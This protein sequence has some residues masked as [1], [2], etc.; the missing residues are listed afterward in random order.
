MSPTYG[1]GVPGDKQPGLPPRSLQDLMN[2][3][4]DDPA[5]VGKHVGRITQASNEIGKGAEASGAARQQG[6]DRIRTILDELNGP[7]A[8]PKRTEASEDPLSRALADTSLGTELDSALSPPTQREVIAVQRGYLSM[9]VTSATQGGSMDQETRTMLIKAQKGFQDALKSMRIELKRKHPED[10]ERLLKEYEERVDSTLE[11]IL[12]TFVEAS[13][14]EETLSTPKR[15]V[16]GT[17]VHFLNKTAA[18]RVIT[19]TLATIIG[20]WF[21]MSKPV[22]NPPQSYPTETARPST[23]EPSPSEQSAVPSAPLI[24]FTIGEGDGGIVVVR[25]LIEVSSNNPWLSQWITEQYEKAKQD[26]IDVSTRERRV[27][28]LAQIL[29]L[30]DPSGPGS[31]SANL[32]PESIVRV[33]GDRILLVTPTRTDV[34]VGPGYTGYRGGDLATF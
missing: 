28:Y 33:E 29:G 21:A 24:E 14:R 3:L 16:I 6:I 10:A 13:K 8:P 9:M 19:G 7:I 23:S 30:Y 4:P 18:G 17:L 15:G 22:Q 31:R 25:R 11:R 2:A 20:F 5:E 34:L 12:S 26:G 1:E 27:E 32:S